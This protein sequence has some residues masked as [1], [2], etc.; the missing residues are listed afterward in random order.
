MTIPAHAGSTLPNVP[1]PDQRMDRHDFTFGILGAPDNQVRPGVVGRETK[2]L[3]SDTPAN[4]IRR[5]YSGSYDILANV[6]HSFQ[7]GP[8]Q[9]IEIF[10]DSPFIAPTDL[11]CSVL[12]FKF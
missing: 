5:N 4:R 12:G 3:I 11:P 9:N 7:N 1:V 2:V 6:D 8:P 10:V